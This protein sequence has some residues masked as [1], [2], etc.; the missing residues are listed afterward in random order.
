MKKLERISQD[1]K[2]R[3]TIWL[4][5]PTGAAWLARIKHQLRQRLR[6]SWITNKRPLECTGNVVDLEGARRFRQAQ[7]RELPECEFSFEQIKRMI[8]EG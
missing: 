7:K 2:Q 6:R 3:Y 5:T 4:Y 8:E 1:I